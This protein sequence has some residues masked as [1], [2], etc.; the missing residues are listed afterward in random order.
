MYCSDYAG[1]TVRWW[2]CIVWM[3]KNK[4][5]VFHL[6]TAEPG[7]GEQ[8]LGWPSPDRPSL[9]CFFHISPLGCVSDILPDPSSLQNLCYTPLLL[10]AVSSHS[11]PSLSDFGV[12]LALPSHQSST[13][14]LLVP[15][16]LKVTKDWN[17]ESVAF[18]QP[19]PASASLRD[20]TMMIAFYSGSPFP[21]LH[22][23]TSSCYLPPPR[24]S[25]SPLMERPVWRMKSGRSMGLRPEWKRQGTKSSMYL[26]SRTSISLPLNLSIFY[27][28]F[29]LLTLWVGNILSRRNVLCIFKETVGNRLVMRPCFPDQLFEWNSNLQRNQ[30]AWAVP[31]AF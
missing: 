7:G 29:Y 30:T 26:D 5:D 28:G 16:F 25:F 2:E 12:P 19:S 8:G 14:H 1:Q 11:L 6:K 20:Q 31:L 3:K 27:F 10:V 24:G 15:V 13:P 4:T 21:C 17:A 22:D 9:F 18:P 23:I